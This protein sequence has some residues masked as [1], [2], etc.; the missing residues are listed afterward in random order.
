MIEVNE[1]YR[2]FGV[3]GEIIA[4]VA[5]ENYGILRAAPQRVAYPDVPIPFARP[6]Q[7]FCLPNSEKNSYRLLVY[8]A[9]LIERE[10]AQ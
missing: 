10:S 5:E 6:M 3:S 9:D 1:D 8:V 4:S 2:S 7:Q